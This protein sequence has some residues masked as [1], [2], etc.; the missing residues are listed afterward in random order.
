M[1]HATFHRAS[2]GPQEDHVA[3]QVPQAAAVMDKEVGDRLPPFE[4]GSAQTP[5]K[6]KRTHP[7]V[8][9]PDGLQH[10]EV[11]QCIGQDQGDRHHRGTAWGLVGGNWNHEW[12]R[13]CNPP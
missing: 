4:G 5:A 9:P 12:G 10:D 3:C 13:V 2:K 6:N 8:G 1:A 7:V 11:R